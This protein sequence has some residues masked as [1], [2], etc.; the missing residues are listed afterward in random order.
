MKPNLC[1]YAAGPWNFSCL[2]WNSTLIRVRMFNRILSDTRPMRALSVGLVLVLGGRRRNDHEN[3]LRRQCRRFAQ[4]IRLC[5]FSEQTTG[6]ES[7]EAHRLAKFP[8]SLMLPPSTS[9]PSHAV[10]SANGPLHV[11]R[12]KTEDISSRQVMHRISV[13]GDYVYSLCN[14]DG[15][16]RPIEFMVT[17]WLYT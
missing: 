3:M 4:C 9:T 11:A 12:S 14:P 5:F 15:S 1:G 10:H 8:Q 17:S 7:G 2:P 13:I 6:Q 16:V